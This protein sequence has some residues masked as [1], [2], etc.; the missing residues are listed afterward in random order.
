MW[1][2]VHGYTRKWRYLNCWQPCECY[3]SD[4][5]STVMFIYISSFDFDLVMCIAGSALNH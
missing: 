4:I 3:Y 1:S 2:M 5:V